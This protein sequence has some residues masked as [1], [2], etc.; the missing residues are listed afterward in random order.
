[1]VDHSAAHSQFSHSASSVGSMMGL[2]QVVL[3]LPQNVFPG[4]GPNEELPLADRTFRDAFFLARI[5]IAST[6]SSR[7]KSLVKAASFPE[8]NLS[9]NSPRTSSLTLPQPF[10]WTS[11][12]MNSFNDS[13]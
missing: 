1:M 13:R 6:F 10:V 5:R 9:S 12:S 8:T 3:V 2:D 7:Q 11:R 4:G